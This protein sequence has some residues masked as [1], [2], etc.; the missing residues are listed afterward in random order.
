M[1]Y[2][3]SAQIVS[4]DSGS[5]FAA[6]DLYKFVVATTA[7]VVLPNTTGNVLPIGVLYGRTSTT[8]A[9]QAVPVAIGGIAKVNMAASTLAAG[10]YVGSSTAGLG[11]A[12]SS[13]A[14]TAGQIVSGSSGGAGRKVSVKLFVGPL[15]TP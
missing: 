7:G 13:D 6:T 2:S 4:M 8:S 15:D 14:Y 11:I 10:D 12:P 1:A 5:T 9:G 3:E